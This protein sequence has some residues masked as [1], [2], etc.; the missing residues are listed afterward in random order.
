MGDKRKQH[1]SVKKQAM[2]F[3][4]QERLHDKLQYDITS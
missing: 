3:I 4:V 1:E 2:V